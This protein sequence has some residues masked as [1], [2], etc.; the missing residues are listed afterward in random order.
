MC[1]FSWRPTE[2]N[3]A[4]G[5]RNGNLLSFQGNQEGLGAQCALEEE[6]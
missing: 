6:E 1:Y 3:V 4:N 2:E 5:T